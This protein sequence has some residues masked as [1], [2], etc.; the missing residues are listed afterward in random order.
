LFGE[1]HDPW[2]WK[3]ILT[4]AWAGQKFVRGID[5]TVVVIPVKTSRLSRK[6]FSELIEAIYAYGSEERVRWSEPAMRAY[7]QYREASS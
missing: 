6:K 3:H 1:S 4:A 2:T 7:G 5:E